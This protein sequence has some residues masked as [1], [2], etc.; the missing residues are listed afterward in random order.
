MTRDEFQAYIV[1]GAADDSKFEDM[2][3]QMIQARGVDRLVWQIASLCDDGE[4]RMRACGLFRSAQ[5]WA[6]MRDGLLSALPLAGEVSFA[7]PRP[8]PTGK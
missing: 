2:V 8:L 5:N 1:A 6:S 3:K 4:K 7:R